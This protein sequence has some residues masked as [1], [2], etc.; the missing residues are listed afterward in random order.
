MPLAGLLGL[1]FSFAHHF[2]AQ[3]TLPALALYRQHFRPSQWLD[4]PYAMVAV[5]ALT[6]SACIAVSA[7]GVAAL[8]RCD[9]HRAGGA[10]VPVHDC[11]G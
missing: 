3:H 2:S 11:V 6:N 10:H 9:R 7:S 8:V 5:N 1:P 4:R